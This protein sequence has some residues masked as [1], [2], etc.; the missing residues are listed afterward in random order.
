M[1]VDAVIE[2]RWGYAI[3]YS[4]SKLNRR[5]RQKNHKLLFHDLALSPQSHERAITSR[6]DL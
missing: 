2:R 5:N 3:S 4:Q 1:A 6:R